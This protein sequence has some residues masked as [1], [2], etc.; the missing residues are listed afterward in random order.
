M[1]K[2]GENIYLRKDG[3]WEGRYIKGKNPGGKPVFG[4]IYGKQ[5]SDVKRRMIIE[6]S[7]LY[8]KPTDCIIYGD[9]T[10]RSWAEYWLENIVR[11]HIK[12][13]TYENYRRNA[14]KHIYPSLGDLQ[15]T[16]ITPDHVQKTVDS[17]QS[18]IA[19]TTLQGVCRLLKSI[20]TAAFEKNLIPQNPYNGI[21]L[22]KAKKRPPRVLSQKEQERLEEKLL[23]NGELEFLLC[24]YT[25][26]RVG[27]LCALRWEDADLE[28]GTLY[29][30]HSVHRIPNEN[31]SPKTHLTLGSPKSADS[32]REIPVPGFIISL[33]KEY[34]TDS[35]EKP[36]GF[37]FR[38]ANG[39]CRD[40]R[41]LQQRIVRICKEL[42]I[43][44]VHMH[45]LRH[46]FATRCLEKGVRYEVLCE[47][48]G[49]SSPQIT[50]R[51]YA[52]CTPDDKR[53]SIELLDRAL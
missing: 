17:L 52:H 38:G 6:K 49:H 31:G 21:R 24:L 13:V 5:Y 40:P 37:L 9:G 25:G 42:G 30:R 11:P 2:K 43:S 33:L 50:L 15:I 23:K 28:N 32:I 44:G 1:A 18:A 47:L 20:L 10:F 16:D 12:S 34:H 48:L 3:R 29:I 8:S 22:P 27:E 36:N 41:T 51:H 14:E 53:K 7:K 45:T 19:P 39:K 4:Y 35:Y 46:T 26:L